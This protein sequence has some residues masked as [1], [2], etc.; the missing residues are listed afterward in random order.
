MPEEN[1]NQAIRDTINILFINDDHFNLLL[2]N[3]NENNNSNNNI[4]QKG[5]NFNEYKTIIL[6]DQ[7]KAKRK[8][9]N[10]IK[11][12]IKTKNYVGYS[13]SQKKNYYN[14]IFKFIKD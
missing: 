10:E 7:K 14:E 12:K 1:M 3:N 13:L 5:I 6:K 11:L 9:N 4:I 2:P 8:I